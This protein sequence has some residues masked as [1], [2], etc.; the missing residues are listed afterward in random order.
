MLPLRVRGVDMV[1]VDATATGTSEVRTL[2]VG[3]SK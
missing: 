3:K 1:E 2:G